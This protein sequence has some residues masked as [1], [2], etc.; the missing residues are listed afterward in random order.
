M[1]QKKSTSKITNKK[2]NDSV[3]QIK[4]TLVE[5]NPQVWR[6]V[7]IPLHFTLQQLHEVIQITMGWQN[8]HLYSFDIS[9]VEYGEDLEDINEEIKDAQKHKLSDILTDKKQFFYLYDFGDDWQHEIIIESILKKE[10]NYNYP[11]CI[12]GQNA[13]PPE[14]SG[15]IYNYQ[16]I[17]ETLNNK[18]HEDHL[19]IITWLGGFFDPLTFDP[20]RINRDHLW[21]RDWD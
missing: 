4:I 9:G 8:S 12:A 1:P 6:R 20:N 16:E 5:S 13:C 18:N 19:E 15:G 3:I 21:M 11:V 2:N 14:D 7:L 10:N 17:L